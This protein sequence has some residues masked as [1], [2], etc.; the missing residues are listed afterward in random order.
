VSINISTLIFVVIVRSS[1][2]SLCLYRI[3]T[4]ER[5]DIRQILCFMY[6][7]SI[8]CQAVLTPSDSVIASL[9]KLNS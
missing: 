9:A 2:D 4:D 6:S 8:C 5:M 7:T 3:R 1:V